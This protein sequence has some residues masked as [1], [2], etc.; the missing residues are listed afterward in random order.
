M[1]SD[2]SCKRRC[3][4]LCCIL[5]FFI[6][7]SFAFAMPQGNEGEG[8]DENCP[9]SLTSLC[10]LPSHNAIDGKTSHEADSVRRELGIGE[11]VHFAIEGKES[12][13]KK[14]RENTVI[15]I[16]DNNN[17][18]LLFAR[19]YAD[20]GLLDGATM[21]LSKTNLG[22]AVYPATVVVELV[23]DG[24]KSSLTFTVV[25]PTGFTA[26]HLEEGTIGEGFLQDFD[27]NVGASAVICVTLLPA[28]VSFANLRFR[29]F[30]AGCTSNNPLLQHEPNQEEGNI[31]GHNSF[32]D[33]FGFCGDQVSV[34]QLVTLST[35]SWTCQFMITIG[36][37][38]HGRL[39]PNDIAQRFVI[40][41]IEDEIDTTIS[42]FGKTVNRTTGEKHEF[43]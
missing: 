4:T 2:T 15:T 33:T 23:I 30:N 40:G 41:Q 27:K 16:K 11:R 25:C 5:G 7:A 17:V 31:D 14:N 35:W 9:V 39:I 19:K 37:L 12:F 21:F 36:G 20:N 1:N 13:R 38:Q 18:V 43:N 29:E 32:T 10:I 34:E 42:K 3:L 8:K 26:E 24:E 28:N 6:L 22:K